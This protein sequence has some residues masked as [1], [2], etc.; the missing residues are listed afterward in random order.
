MRRV[1][2]ARRSSVL[3]VMFFLVFGMFSAL[4]ASAST[5]NAPTAV[6]VS[7]LLSTSSTAVVS[8]TAPTPVTGVT[9]T[10]YVVTSSVGGLTCVTSTLTCSVPGLSP[11]TA[12][13]F[14]VSAQSSGGAGPS[15]SSSSWTSPT[16]I[17]TTTTMSAS[18]NGPQNVGT[19]IA[20]SAIV[21]SGA[22]GTVQF[23]N[24][25]TAITGCAAVVLNSGYAGCSTAGLVSG[26]NSL[27][28]VYSGNAKYAT[29]TSSTLV[30][31]MAS[32]TLSA[33]S[34]P[35]V[36]TTIDTPINTTMTL[37]T[38]GGN[39]SGA[40]TYS[41]TN[42]S[43]TGC[44]ISSGIISVP[45]NVSGTCLVTAAQASTS[46]YLGE[47]SNVTAF[48]F[49]WKYAAAW[50]TSITSY[51][52]SSAGTVSFN[53]SSYVCTYTATASY[54]CPSGGTLS[55][56]NCVTQSSTVYLSQCVNNSNGTAVWTSWSYNAPYYGM[57]TWTKAATLTETCPSGGTSGGTT[58]CTYAATPNYS[59]Y[60]SCPLGG[61]LSTT[62]CSISGGSGPNLRR[63]SQSVSRQFLSKVRK[64]ALGGTS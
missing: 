11:S 23:K 34:S 21:T 41:V 39:G 57:C 17:S 15:G 5:P 4:P 47:S 12:Y 20:L 3:S 1:S 56:S 30:Y 37:V 63:S 33:P 16:L 14:S 9:I 40:I 51:S 27:S 22:T 55:G 38:S 24:G 61:S 52:C 28:A 53:G 44:S 42:G 29:S 25:S 8:W 7:T 48:N 62:T 32:S 19:V 58:T 60:W 31:T 50:T 10:G 18:P 45:T 43:A 59:S 49:F 13:V 36:I 64:D 54:S 2:I 6:T 35:L 46:S 26:S